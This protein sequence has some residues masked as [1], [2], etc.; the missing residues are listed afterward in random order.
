MPVAPEYQP[1]IDRINPSRERFQAVDNGGGIAGGIGRGVQKLAGA[2]SQA[3][4]VQDQINAHYDSITARKKA[5]D[6]RKEASAL[7]M[8]FEA[9]EG[10]DALNNA[11]AYDTQLKELGERY[12]SSMT[13]ERQ[14][15]FLTD[16]ID[17]FEAETGLNMSGHLM[18]AQK[19]LY[20]TTLKAELGEA[21]QNAA[22]SIDRPDAFAGYMSDVDEIIREQQTL[23]GWSPEITQSMT[24][25]TKSTIHS[26][27]L[28][29]M[30]SRTNADVELASA[31][32]DANKD[33]M[34][35]ADRNTMQSA[36]QGPLD[37]RMARDI[38]M[39]VT[40]G[41]SSLSS[42]DSDAGE[43]G[44]S[45]GAAVSAPRVMPV[46]GQVTQSHADHTNREKPSAGIDI[47]APA[48]T[49]IKAAADG[50]VIESRKG[51]SGG[52]F[53]RVRHPDGTV[54]SYMHMENVSTF[55]KGDRVTRGAVI[56][57]V[58]QTGNAT[59]PHLHM[60][61]KDASGNQ[62]D[63][64]E[65]LNGA[66]AI[67]NPDEPREWDIGQVRAGID[68][69]VESGE[70]TIE[71]GEKAWNYAQTRMNRDQTIINQR[72][73]QAYEDAQD[74]LLETGMDG[75]TDFNQIPESIRSRLNSAQALTLT[76]M[77]QS[78]KEALA[79]SSI[80]T[81]GPTS[82]SLSLMAEEGSPQFRDLDLTKYA[83]LIHPSEFEALRKQQIKM[84]QESSGWTPEAGVNEALSRLG[85]YDVEGGFK[86]KDKLGM[87]QIM[88]KRAYELFEQ[89]GNKPLSKAQYDEAYRYA[90]DENGAVGESTFGIFSSG[91][92]NLPRF[93]AD[94]VVENAA[95]FNDEMA[96]QR[97]SKR[98]GERRARV[99]Q[100]WREAHD[101]ADPNEAQIQQWLPLVP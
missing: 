22:G 29:D 85:G 36:L 57:T 39:K 42:A 64:E 60:E 16:A 91:K 35:S 30:L 27:V 78:N 67:G 99:I 54:S 11:P 80:K 50:E 86:G 40:S 100:A 56:G 47:P 5:L 59:G 12:R 52:N 8:Q 97:Q 21:I 53:I 25:Q 92:Y 61:V 94:D 83:G 15:R 76:N 10:E 51:T 73:S 70:I 23:Y 65:W 98:M 19:K 43:G 6:Y 9:L 101:G 49:S 37:Q 34:T 55:Q 81:N 24:R 26:D 28:K 62:T 48:G 88:K 66:S 89:N 17:P 95:K 1:Q 7:R 20:E 41:A 93:E 4:E 14:K 58:G 32:F 13:T 87:L 38:F 79:G 69:M 96:T 18:G 75:F 72:Q 2:A 84:R 46:E 63:P 74:W 77:A 44:G 45:A 68:A 33:E 82:I 71:M 90:I 31:Y 3:I